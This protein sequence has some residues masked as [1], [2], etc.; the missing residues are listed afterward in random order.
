MVLWVEDELNLGSLRSVDAAGRI[1]EDS[2]RANGNLNSPVAGS[3]DSSEGS[4]AK[5]SA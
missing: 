4:K 2:I 3:V 1:F 5:D